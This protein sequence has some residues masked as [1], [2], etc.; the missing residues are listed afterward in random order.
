MWQE[1]FGSVHPTRPTPEQKSKHFQTEK[2]FVV[3]GVFNFSMNFRSVAHNNT[4]SKW[5]L[6]E[7]HT[8]FPFRILVYFGGTHL[9]TSCTYFPYT[10]YTFVQPENHTLTPI[11]SFSRSF[12]VEQRRNR[13]SFPSSEF[14]FSVCSAFFFK[15]KIDARKLFSSKF[16]FCLNECKIIPWRSVCSI[17]R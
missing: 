15:W 11:C 8:N 1:K 12:K 17:D 16:S 4:M 10:Q 14:C 2:S 7:N 5:K 6:L 9:R 13:W 3:V